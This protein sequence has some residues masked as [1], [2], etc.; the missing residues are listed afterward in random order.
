[1]DV[2]RKRGPEN[3][4]FRLSLRLFFR[5][6]VLPKKEN[7]YK[8]TI[9]EKT[10]KKEKDKSDKKDTAASPSFFR[11][12]AATWHNET[13]RFIVGLMLVIFSVYLLLAFSS[14]FFTG[15]ADQSILDSGNGKDL[16]AVDNGVKNYAGSRGAQLSSYLINDCFGISSFFILVFLAAAGLK[17][18]KVRHIRLWRWFI[19][20]SLLLVWFLVFFGFAFA[21]LYEDSFIYLGG[22]H[23]YNV[24]RWLASQVG[25]PGVWL[26]LL[27]TAICF[28]IY[29]SA[30]TVVW[31]RGVFALNFLKK[32]KDGQE[33]AEGEVPE[34][35][36]T[37]WTAEGKK[38]PTPTPTSAVA[39]EP[40]PVVEE[41]AE[42]EPEPEEEPEAEPSQ[43][44]SLDLGGPL[45]PAA[46]GNRG[47]EVEMT[48][49]A[50]EPEP[51]VPLEPAEA[52]HA[53][54]PEFQVETREEEEYQGPELEPYNPRL[55][56]ENYHFPT[57]DLMKHYDNAEPTI[58]MDEQN[59]N[60]DKIVST[61]RS[62]GIEISSIKATVGPTVTLYEITPEQ[63]VR[64]S[65]IR[66]LEDDIALSLSALGI[67]IIAPIPGKGTIGIEVPNSNP[68]IVS[69]QSIIG[70][71]KFQESTYELPIALGKTITN[72]VFM[73][74]LAKMP[75][76]LV[77]GATGQGKSVGLNAIITSL[78]Y[79]KH[80]AE[81][82]FVLVDPKKVEF[83]IYSV[84]EHHFLA[85]LPDE[86][87][88]IITDVTKV[89]QTLNSIC[90][91][92]DTR[93]DL[94]KAAHVRNIK[95]YNE[96]FINRRLNPEKGH[97][98]MP[99][100]VVVIDE[101]GDLIMTAGK[102]VELPIARIAQLARA[103]GIHMIIATQRPTTNIITG[104]I[105]ANFPARIAFRVSAMVDSRTILDR[106]GANQLIGRG[107]MLFLQGADPVRVQCAFIDTPEV[108]EITKFIA[109]QQGYPTAFY[110]PEYVDENASGSDLGDVDL[111]RKDPL[112]DDAARLIVT[113]QQGST[114][115]IQR[116]FSIGYNR[117][118]RLMDQL[119]KA[120]I[121]GPAQGS[122]PRDVYFTDI[123]SLE[124]FLSKM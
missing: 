112:F 39:E 75:H 108:A 34:E 29:F 24:S 53:D 19:C 80:P 103:V 59:A 107:D 91:E 83:S 8:K 96:K 12:V 92:M 28:L 40:K 41:K 99:Y 65:K 94:L 70:S 35:F 116:K 45:R 10:M 51:A 14:F 32:K 2:L 57:L 58:D 86:A 113:H 93:Y 42:E 30:R 114:S 15:A 77:A 120:G 43:E 16:M 89:V 102:D 106:P 7:P 47:G 1:M 115:L 18:M 90:V 82:K 17:L 105:K 62:F 81:L 69:G 49:E 3:L 26:L 66:G 85:K 122:K 87:E 101:F 111:G 123:V 5:I 88:P 33:K 25:A 67:R 9:I 31:L 61:L 55:D 78:L 98:Y 11:K 46:T 63:G 73:V 72:E 50:A 37:S 60:K 76:V 13:L 74:D 121:V 100:I 23:G 6:F 97:K 117:A 48:V 109:R 27:V 36:T 38:R 110:L 64:I 104:T 44:I 22:M 84:I 21:S 4:I 52:P 54:D 68:K 124:D 71:K 119:E 79:K 118:G 95:E 20:C 56:L